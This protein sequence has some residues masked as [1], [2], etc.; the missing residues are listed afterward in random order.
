MPSQDSSAD[1]LR[2]VGQERLVGAL[3]LLRHPAYENMLT[4]YRVMREE[5]RDHLEVC[6]HE[7]VPYYRGRLAQL[8]SITNLSERISRLVDGKEK[9]K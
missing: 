5:L 1:R 2:N 8:R 9:P 3:E 6:A 4:V 7:E